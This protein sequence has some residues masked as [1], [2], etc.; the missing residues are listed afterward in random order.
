MILLLVRYDVV[1]IHKHRGW[2]D[3]SEWPRCMALPESED[4]GGTLDILV[5]FL[6]SLI[7]AR[8]RIY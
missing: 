7:F 4:L 3:K 6:Y 1:C 8:A 5:L 2:S